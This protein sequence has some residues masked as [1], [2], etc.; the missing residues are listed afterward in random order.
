MSVANDFVKGLKT[1][2]LWGD[3]EYRIQVCEYQEIAKPD[4]YID[5]SDEE[6][7]WSEQLPLPLT[8]EIARTIALGL[9][10][11]ADKQGRQP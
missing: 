2:V 8:A 9:M 11:W 5:Y 3:D 4:L 1:T 6:G 7:D 10:V